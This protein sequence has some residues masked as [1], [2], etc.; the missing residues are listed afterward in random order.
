MRG[1]Y[2]YKSIAIHLCTDLLL[3][4]SIFIFRFLTM[5][6]DRFPYRTFQVIGVVQII[7]GILFVCEGCVR[8]GIVLVLTY[9]DSISIIYLP[10]IADVVTHAVLRFGA[11]VVGIIVSRYA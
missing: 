4:R 5:A 3:T 2:V 10:P 8:T 1:N 6:F 11:I 7:M 9:S